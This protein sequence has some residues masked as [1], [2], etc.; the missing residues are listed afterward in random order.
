MCLE[1][2][3]EGFVRPLRRSSPPELIDGGVPEHPV[4]PRDDRF[5]VRRVV[6]PRDHFGERILEDVFGERAVPDAALEVSQE[7]T[8][9]LE[10]RSDRNGVPR[11]VHDPIVLVPRMRPAL[12]ARPGSA[13]RVC[14]VSRENRACVVK[15]CADG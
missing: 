12:Y 1:F 3:G 2:A 7:Q 15:R 9:V 11:L 13:I 6:R 8:M 10:Q 5:I 4:E 14:R